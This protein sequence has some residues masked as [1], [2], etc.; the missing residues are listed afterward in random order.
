[1]DKDML[2]ASLQESK[3]ALCQAPTDVTVVPELL[4]NDEIWWGM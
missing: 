2:L 3:D 1:M 4:Y